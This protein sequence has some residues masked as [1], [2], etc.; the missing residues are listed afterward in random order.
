MRD[1]QHAEPEKAADT[2]PAEIAQAEEKNHV[3]ACKAAPQV[4]QV[5]NRTLTRCAA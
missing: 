2:L 3:V 1:Q 4:A 5:R